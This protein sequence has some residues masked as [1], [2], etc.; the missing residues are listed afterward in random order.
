MRLLEVRR[1]GGEGEDLYAEGLQFSFRLLADFVD[2][3]VREGDIRA[4]LRKSESDLLSDPSRRAGN[5]RRGA[6]E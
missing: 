3:Q 2:D 6:T 4:F 1:V 5:Q